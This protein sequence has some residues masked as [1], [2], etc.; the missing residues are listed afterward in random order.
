[1]KNIFYILTISLLLAAQNIHAQEKAM[2]LA[3]AGFEQPEGGG[4]SPVE[5]EPIVY[6]EGNGAVQPTQDPSEIY[7]ETIVHEGSAV[8]P[9]SSEDFPGFDKMIS[10]DLRGMSVNDVLK[11]LAVEGDL[12]IAIAPDVS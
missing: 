1:M 3:P 8:P 12:N 7:S 4:A 6:S 10:V 11:F 2:K 5:L 9:I